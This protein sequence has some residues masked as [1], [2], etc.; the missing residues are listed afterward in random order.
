[1]RTVSGEPTGPIH[2]DPKDPGQTGANPDRDIGLFH[3][4]MGM[5]KTTN[6]QLCLDHSD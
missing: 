3:P 1:M 6:Q 4:S 2:V 5:F